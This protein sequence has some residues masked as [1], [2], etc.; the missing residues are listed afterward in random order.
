[1][2][3]S[4]EHNEMLSYQQAKKYYDK[5]G[6][7][8]DTQGF[9]EDTA[10]DDLISNS[11][12][13][14]AKHIFEFGCGTGKFAVRL[15]KG[16]LGENTTYFGVDLSS[17]MVNI[18]A[19]RLRNC[20]PRAKV[21]KSEGD[22]AFPLDDGAVDRVISNY[23]LDLLREDD[24]RLFFNEAYRVLT[25]GG[26]L[27][28]VSLTDGITPASRLVSSL[29]KSVFKLRPSLVGGCRPVQLESFT[30]PKRW[31][32]AYHAKKSAFGVPSDII[33]L[34]RLH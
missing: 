10:L 22:I 24:I 3:G 34:K 13:Q 8:Q 29:W 5:F 33:V 21:E 31:E 17:T 16:L 4:T 9:Y 20:S 27:C 18:A 11:R 26:M 32:V 2:T 23:V 14:D 19:E 7:K 6:K 28:L 12:F 25:D 15:F 30:D 1:M